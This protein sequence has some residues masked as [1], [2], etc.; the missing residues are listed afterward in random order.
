P[1]STKRLRVR[2]TVATPTWRA[3]AM[4]TSVVPSSA[5]SR[6]WTRQTVRAATLPFLRKLSNCWRS[7]SLN[8]TRD[9]FAIVPLLH[10]Y[11]TRRRHPQ[12]TPCG[13]VVEPFIAQAGGLVV[14]VGQ[15]LAALEVSRAEHEV[16]PLGVELLCFPRGHGVSRGGPMEQILHD[17]IKA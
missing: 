4:P 11:S 6:I 15:D 14:A 1:S 13:G 8:S 7:S 9:F 10:S 17:G 5:W 16:I 2:S 12:Q 3:A